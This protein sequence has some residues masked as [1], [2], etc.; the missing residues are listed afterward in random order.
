VF[1]LLAVALLAVACAPTSIVLQPGKAE[2]GEAQD[3][4]ADAWSLWVGEVKDLRTNAAEGTKVGLFYPK[5]VTEPQTVYV[6]PEPARYVRDELSRFLLHRG[7][8]A[9]AANR[10]KLHLRSELTDFSLVEKPGPV[11]DEITVRVE[12]TVRF[13]TP[14]G[15]ELGSLRLEGSSIIRTPVSASRKAEEGFRDALSDTF[16]PLLASEVFGRALDQVR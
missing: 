3:G 9:S 7:L 16:E 14:Q 10:A 2:W 13:T 5:L 6:A 11:M 4:G 1:L 12:Y 8:E 15:A